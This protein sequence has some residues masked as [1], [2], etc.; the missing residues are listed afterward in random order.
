MS[1]YEKDSIQRITT[2]ININKNQIIKPQ[3]KNRM[4]RLEKGSSMRLFVELEMETM[5]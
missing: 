5:P 4:G 3:K 2:A 1:S